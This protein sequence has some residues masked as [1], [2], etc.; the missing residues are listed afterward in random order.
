MFDLVS[1]EWD[2]LRLEFQTAAEDVVRGMQHD[3]ATEG[4][5]VCKVKISLVGADMVEDPTSEGGEPEIRKVKYEYMD[6]AVG[7]VLNNVRVITRKGLDP[8]FQES[9]D[10]PAIFCGETRGGKMRSLTDKEIFCIRRWVFW[11]F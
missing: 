9:Y 2:E 3:G 8:H 11:Y 4:E 6:E 1:K 7:D 10:A 5:I